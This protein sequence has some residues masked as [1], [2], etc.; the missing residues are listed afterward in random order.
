M[1]RRRNSRFTC[2]FKSFA[3]R[4]VFHAGSSVRALVPCRLLKVKPQPPL[5]VRE[6]TSERAGGGGGGGGEGFRSFAARPVPRIYVARVLHRSVAT[7]HRPINIFIGLSIFPFPLPP[8]RPH[9][10]RHRVSNRRLAAYTIRELYSS[11]S[12]LVFSSWR[13]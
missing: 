7:S 2:P 9:S 1:E 12:A 13:Q 3:N 8:P 11:L 4:H 5:T 6:G 10:F